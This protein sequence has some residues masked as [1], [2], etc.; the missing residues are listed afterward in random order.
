MTNEKKPAEIKKLVN[1]FYGNYC[2]R[3]CY[4]DI[5]RQHDHWEKLQE[6]AKKLE[7]VRM[8]HKDFLHMLRSDRTIC[9]LSDEE[10][11]SRKFS[12]TRSDCQL[13]RMLRIR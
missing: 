11:K 12:W 6:L 9:N 8:T 10:W 3:K 7:G 4:D 5:D 13:C 2:S 1:W